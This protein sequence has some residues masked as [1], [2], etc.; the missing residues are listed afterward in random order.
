[1]LCLLSWRRGGARLHNGLRS[2]A[3][4]AARGMRLSAAAAAS[5][6][7]ALRRG[8]WRAA[9]A[10]ALPPSAVLRCP[11][12]AALHTP[13][14]AARTA[15]HRLR[16]SVFASAR[17]SSSSAAAPPLATIS[18]DDDGRSF[19]GVDAVIVLAG[20]LTPEGG[21]PPWVEA[22]LDAAAAVH[23]AL[24]VPI[25]CTGGGTPHRPPFVA[26]GSGGYVVHEG[27]ACCAYLERTHGV[28]ATALLK[29]SASY[30]TVGNAWFS[31]TAHAAPAG[32]RAPLVVTSAFHMPRSR[33]CFE[34]VFGL[35]P[36]AG[37]VPRF[38]STPDRGMAPDVAAARRAR[39]Q[40]SLGALRRNAEVR[41][42]QAFHG[43]LH[44][45]H[46]CYAVSR[47]NE[48]GAKPP[49]MADKALASY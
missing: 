36:A 35:T 28:A 25:L 18:C 29:E 40:E 37:G 41:T 31:L 10:P 30:D 39:E 38:L 4:I 44:D 45:T 6:P 26:A 15:N 32:W 23:K 46:M 1:L 20:G 21:L 48:W 11:Q 7:A 43:W 5:A 8:L 12:P 49:A 13:F 34:W 24:R 9:S 33:A 16:T 2:Y 27:T 3:R 42:L 19:D 22:R 47:Q 17:A 14:A